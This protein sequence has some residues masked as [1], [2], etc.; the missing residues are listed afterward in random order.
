MAKK[1]LPRGIRNC[2]PLNIRRNPHNKWVGEVEY[3]ATVT[4]YNGQE[5]EAREFDRTFCQF[6]QMEQGYRA[7]AILLYRYIERGC[8]TYEK[9]LNRWAPAN[10][11]NTAEYINRVTNFCFARPDQKVDFCTDEILPLMAAMTM[12]E[13]GERYDPYN[14]N[15]DLLKAMFGGY[16]LAAKYVARS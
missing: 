8:N 13:N 15:E 12:V 3:K 9:I 11:N 6:A 4:E 2:N 7:A 5:C 14:G 16:M 10:E 1:K